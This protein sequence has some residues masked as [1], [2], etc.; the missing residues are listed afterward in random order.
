MFTREHVQAIATWEI[1][2][3]FIAHSLGTRATSC[4][5]VAMLMELQYSE[6]VKLMCVHVLADNSVL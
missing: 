4:V 5:S 6:Y 3:Y 2:K 1:N